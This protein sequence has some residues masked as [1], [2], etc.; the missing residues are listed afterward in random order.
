MVALNVQES[1]TTLTIAA[2]VE[3]EAA[4]AEEAEASAVL[5]GMTDA[6][7]GSA[8]AEAHTRMNL[9]GR[10]VRRIFKK[11]PQ[12]PVMVDPVLL[13]LQVLGMALQAVVTAN[14]LPLLQR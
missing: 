14:H 6:T 7:F 4:V 11:V 8:T 13:A 10:S 2:D 3:D 5:T 1:G 9:A 12:G